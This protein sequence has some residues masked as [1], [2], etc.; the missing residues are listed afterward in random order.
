MTSKGA[1]EFSDEDEDTVV[2]LLAAAGVA[3]G[4]ARSFDD[5]R[6]RER[7]LARRPG[8]S[9]ATIDVIEGPR[10][11]VNA[12]RDAGSCSD[13]ILALRID[14]KDADAL[15]TQADE[16]AWARVDAAAGPEAEK[17]LHQRLRQLPGF[18]DLTRD[19]TKAL[20]KLDLFRPADPDRAT[21]VIW[22]RVGPEQ[23]GLLILSRP[24]TIGWLMAKWSRPQP[25]PTRLRW[26]WCTHR[27]STTDTGWRLLRSGPHRPGLARPCHPTHLRR[28]AGLQSIVRR[29]PDEGAAN[30][31]RRYIGDL[32]APITDIRNTIFSLQ[33]KPY[34]GKRSL[35]DDLLV[36]LT[37]RQT[38]SDSTHR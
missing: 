7:W 10:L 11:I 26:P 21:A 6:R 23:V 9:P 30:R 27:P 17:L 4:N 8:A 28:R 32:D 18:R 34:G 15:I 3:I 1:A 14:V 2:G 20:L 38:P 24:R 37:T 29:L 33:H 31:I 12:V 16:D 25:S 5:A 36:S 35:R 22:L 19:G 13:V